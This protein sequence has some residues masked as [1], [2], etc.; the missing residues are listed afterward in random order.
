MCLRQ[1]IPHVPMAVI[2]Y[3]HPILQTTHLQKPEHAHTCIIM[4]HMEPICKSEG[5]RIMQQTNSQMLNRKTNCDKQPH[6]NN[7]WKELV[8]AYHAEKDSMH[9]QQQKTTSAY[10]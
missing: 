6:T 4:M 7:T 9:M 5:P 2:L 10:V 3:L 8:Q 1:I